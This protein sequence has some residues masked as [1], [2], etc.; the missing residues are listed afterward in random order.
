MNKIQIIHICGDWHGQWDYVNSFINKHIRE[1]KTLRELYNQYDEVEVLILQVGD[2]GFWPHYHM[3]KNFTGKSLWNQYGIKNKV[4]GLKDNYVKI[5][6]CG[7]N[8]EN[9][10]TLDELENTHPVGEFIEIMP[11]VHYAPFGSLLK[12]LDGTTIMFCGGADS[13]DKRQRIAGDTWWP[14]EVITYK[15][16]LKLPDPKQIKVDWIISHTCPT[17]FDLSKLGFNNKGND[18][19]HKNLEWILNNFRP[20]KWWFGHYHQYMTST[21]KDCQWMMLDRIDNFYGKKWC[22]TISIK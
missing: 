9:W 3:T 6:W 21:Y 16:M 2:F 1:S 7:G 19:S 4:E 17:S 14:Q 5:Y 11:Q 12:L 20:S 22:H 18:P 8:H 10:D 13:I 15:D